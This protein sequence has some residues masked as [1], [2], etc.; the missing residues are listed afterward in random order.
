MR[1]ALLLTGLTGLFVAAALARDKE[2]EV[3]PMIAWQA[4]TISSHAAGL[5][6]G[7]V[8]SPS[9]TPSASALRPGYVEAQPIGPVEPLAPLPE[10]SAVI[11]DF[12]LL[13]PR[14]RGR[15]RLTEGEM[16]IAMEMADVPQEWQRDFLALAWCESR[17][18]PG[19]IGDGGAS[20]GLLQIQPY[21]G[22]RHLWRLEA[23]GY[24]PDPELLLD[25]II[26]LEVGVHIRETNGNFR[27]WSC[28]R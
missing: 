26:N 19:A 2:P 1:W 24:E 16:G 7:L 13:R 3:R 5:R 4:Q 8:T 27:A 22:G 6:E 12:S 21:A 23:L 14:F 10:L 28:A 25:P 15:S 20:L 18:Q 11:P 17:Y 9:P